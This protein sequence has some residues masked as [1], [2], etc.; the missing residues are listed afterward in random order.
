MRDAGLIS[1]PGRGAVLEAFQ[2]SRKSGTADLSS[3]LADSTFKR[4]VLVRD[5]TREYK[6]VVRWVSCVIVL[7]DTMAEFYF[8][9]VR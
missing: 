1:S 5:C 3:D 7:S 6:F 8:V 4:R 2:L 9:A